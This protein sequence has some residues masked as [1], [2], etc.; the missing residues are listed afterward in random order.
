MLQLESMARS[1]G[2][3]GLRDGEDWARTPGLATGQ[4]VLVNEGEEEGASVSLFSWRQCSPTGPSQSLPGGIGVWQRPQGWAPPAGPPAPLQPAALPSQD[5]PASS[6]ERLSMEAALGRYDE[7]TLNM[8]QNGTR[9]LLLCL[10]IVCVSRW[11]P[12]LLWTK[13]TNN[14]NKVISTWTW[15]H[16]WFRFKGKYSLGV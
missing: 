4:G 3:V 8:V 12:D 6:T 1:H 10:Y 9:L 2:H 15:S 11:M 14:N 13:H 7:H 5:G 16:S